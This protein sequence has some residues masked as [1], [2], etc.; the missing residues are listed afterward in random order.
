MISSSNTKFVYPRPFKK[1][2]LYFEDTTCFSYLHRTMSL[3][4]WAFN[5]PLTHF[6]PL[7][8][9][10]LAIQ[11]VH[12]AEKNNYR[13]GDREN[14]IIKPCIFKIR[15]IYPK[16]LDCYNQVDWGFGKYYFENKVYL[17]SEAEGQVSELP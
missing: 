3:V 2:G 9:S 6:F 4:N 11:V 16:H 7:E 15:S 17:K 10:S 1:S 13:K 8:D 12:N 14:V 5:F